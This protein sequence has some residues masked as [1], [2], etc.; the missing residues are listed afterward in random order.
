MNEVITAITECCQTEL[1]LG[2]KMRSKETWI[3]KSRTTAVIIEAYNW[4]GK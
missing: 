2:P 1:T 3:K 4:A